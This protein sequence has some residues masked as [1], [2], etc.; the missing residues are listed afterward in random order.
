MDLITDVYRGDLERT[1]EMVFQT[2]I[3]L[4]VVPSDEPWIKRIGTLTA[5][6]HFAGQWK[7]SVY[8]EFT[9]EQALDITTRLM[10]IPSPETID[11]DVLDAIGEMANMVGGNMK[12]VMP[13]GVELSAPTVVEGGDYA[14]RFRA[15]DAITRAA[16]QSPAGPFWITLVERAE[17]PA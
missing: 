14:L 4:T 11:D 13:R 16:F 12:S 10:G 9:R 1:A 2:M 3:G 6:V 15:G 7:G 8:I 17:T 5:A